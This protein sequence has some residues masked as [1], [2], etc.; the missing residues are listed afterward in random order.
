MLFVPYYHLSHRKYR[1]HHVYFFKRNLLNFT[2]YYFITFSYFRSIISMLKKIVWYELWN[3]F[4]LLWK[5]K[6]SWNLFVNKNMIKRF[7]YL[8]KRS[9]MYD[10]RIH[11]VNVIEFIYSVILISVLW[12]VLFRIMRI[13]HSSELYI[14]HN[15]NILNGKDILNRFSE[16]WQ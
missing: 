4:C 2:I 6:F 7:G 12:S 11:E 5:S 15:N 14:S 1:N 8:H 3:L 16:F 13:F 10:L 9:M